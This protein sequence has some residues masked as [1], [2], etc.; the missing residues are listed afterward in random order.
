MASSRGGFFFFFIFFGFQEIVLMAEKF[1]NMVSK[2][3]FS[4]RRMIPKK[5][6]DEKKIQR[7]GFV[8]TLPFYHLSIQLY[9]CSY[10]RTVSDQK[11][12][13]HSATIPQ[14]TMKSRKSHFQ[15]QARAISIRDT[16][17]PGA[18]FPSYSLRHQLPNLSLQI[19]KHQIS[20]FDLPIHSPS[21]LLLPWTPSVLK[22]RTGF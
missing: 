21:E 9:P 4:E 22:P 13:E 2:K 20:N 14:N 17:H 10:N 5:C 3:G 1:R 7:M 15:P 12:V 8:P 18:V 19:F 6:H 11:L 16:I